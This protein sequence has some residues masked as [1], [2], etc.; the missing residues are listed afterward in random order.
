MWPEHGACKLVRPSSD[1][2]SLQVNDF[3]LACTS[4]PFSLISDFDIEAT[5]S[6]KVIAEHGSV[7]TLGVADVD[8]PSTALRGGRFV[9]DTANEQLLT[10]LLPQLVH[11]AATTNTSERVRTLLKM[12]EA[13]SSAP[14]PG[15]EFVIARLMELILVE[16]L[17][18]RAY[19]PDQTQA[20]LLSGLADSVIEKALV[21]IHGNVAQPWT[22]AKLARLCGTSRSALSARFSRIIGVGLIEYQQ[23]WRIALAKDELRRRT[24]SAGD[25]ALT[26]GFLSGCA[27]S[28]AFT[29]TVG[30]S[31]THFM[32]KDCS[33]AEF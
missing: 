5:E 31:P 15:S 10:G 30:C 4:T 26:I 17:R 11:I 3:V 12:N 25:I 29:R 24:R 32:D 20:V 2:L 9:F 19:G 7:A 21:A 8:R 33:T 1:P 23:Q 16:I 14:R 28:T 6:E 27:F 13:E 18:S 22:T